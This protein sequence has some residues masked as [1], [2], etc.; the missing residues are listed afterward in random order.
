MDLVEQDGGRGGLA[1]DFAR[2]RLL[3]PPTIKTKTLL[4]IRRMAE[5]EGFEPSRDLSASYSFSKAASSAT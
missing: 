5:G 4:R 3:I 1:L 2:A